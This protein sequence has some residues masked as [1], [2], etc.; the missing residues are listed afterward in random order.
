M[1]EYCPL[2][3]LP[4]LCFPTWSIPIPFTDITGLPVNLGPFLLLIVTKLILPQSSL[5]GHLAGIVIGFPLAWGMLDW[6]TPPVLGAILVG[7]YVY[8]DGLWVW[9]LPGYI[10]LQCIIQCAHNCWLYVRYSRYAEM[11]PIESS[12]NVSMT[13][14]CSFSNDVVLEGVVSPQDLKEFQWLRFAGAMLAV[15]TLLVFPF[16]AVQSSSLSSAL[17]TQFWHQIFPHLTL[18]G[19]NLQS[20]MCN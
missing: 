4:S 20:F 3:F 5:T 8:L 11:R 12:T 7:C 13:G 17:T 15:E 18:L 9:R 14:I 10:C 16:C 6:I 19:I 1:T 2:F